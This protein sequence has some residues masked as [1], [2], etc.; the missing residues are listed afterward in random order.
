MNI[1]KR[2]SLGVL[3]TLFLSISANADKIKIG[4][5]ER[6]HLGILKMLQAN[7]LVLKLN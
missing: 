5:E 7:L 6:T 3:I 1:I 2:F 4:T